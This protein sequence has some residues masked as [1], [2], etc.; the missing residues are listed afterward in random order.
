M[1]APAYRQILEHARPPELGVD[2]HFDEVRAERGPD[3]TFQRWVRCGRTDAHIVALWQAFFRDLKFESFRRL[4][5]RIAGL[6]GRAAAGLA[7]RVW[8]AVGITRHDFD[9]R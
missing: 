6:N 4:N 9:L 3:L 5:N 8:A 1:E 2:F 7:D